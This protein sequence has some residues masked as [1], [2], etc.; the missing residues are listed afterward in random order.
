MF[1]DKKAVIWDLDNTLYRITPEFA[2]KLD[3]VMEK[4]C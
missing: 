4:A 3:E 1:C 2:D